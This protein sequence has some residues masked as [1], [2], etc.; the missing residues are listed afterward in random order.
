[1]FDRH[2][3]FTVVDVDREALR[4][5]DTDNTRRPVHTERSKRLPHPR[6]ATDLPSIRGVEN[7]IP[8][9]V[10]VPHNNE[11]PA[12][13]SGGGSNR[14]RIN[15]NQNQEEPTGGSVFDFMAYITLRTR[16]WRLWCS[17]TP[18]FLLV[19]YPARSELGWE[20]SNC[21]ACQRSPKADYRYDL[22]GA[23][24][25]NEIWVE[26]LRNILRNYSV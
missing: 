7:Q 5:A 2:V 3:Q 15:E 17:S 22:H 24:R 16:F 8:P 10:R 9:K 1:M 25:P 19:D 11:M 21:G 20:P 18:G 26:F 14:N 6:L 12:R 23:Q 13:R 4:T